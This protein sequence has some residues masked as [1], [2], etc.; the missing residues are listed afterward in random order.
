MRRP[1]R[2]VGAMGMRPREVVTQ[3]FGIKSRP[4][5]VYGLQCAADCRR[6]VTVRI[7]KALPGVPPSFGPG[8]ADSHGEREELTCT[9]QSA[10]GVCRDASGR[11]HARR[12][13]DGQAGAQAADYLPG[14]REG[15]RSEDQHSRGLAGATHLLCRQG[16]R[17]HLSQGP[18]EG[19]CKDRCGERDAREHPDDPPGQRRAARRRRHGRAGDDQLQRADG[20]VLL[21]TVSPLSFKRTRQGT[22]PSS[23]ANSPRAT[24]GPRSDDSGRHRPTGALLAFRAHPLSPCALRSAL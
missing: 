7:Y 9:Q 18:G 15:H 12:C 10:R 13:D 1:G 8:E 17:G 5:I 19:F 11:G 20:E 21:Q 23:P 16:R 14:D 24:D 3:F 2:A 4:P 22:W 6:G